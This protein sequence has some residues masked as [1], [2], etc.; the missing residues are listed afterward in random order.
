MSSINFCLYIKLYNMDVSLIITTIN[1]PNSNIRS[2]SKGCKNN[3]DF[4]VIGDKKTPKNFKLSYGN[5]F[6]IQSQK[7]SIQNLQEFA[8]IITMH[9]RI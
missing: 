2:F 6:N 8:L 9:E 4:V 3:W 1:K 5:Y 7:N